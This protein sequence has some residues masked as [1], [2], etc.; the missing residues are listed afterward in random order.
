MGSILTPNQLSFEPGRRVRPQNEKDPKVGTGGGRYRPHT[1]IEK[2]QNESKNC[3]NCI[4][5]T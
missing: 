4:Y 1:K 2:K 3:Y 5:I